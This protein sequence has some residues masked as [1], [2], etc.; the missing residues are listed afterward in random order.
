MKVKTIRLYK[1]NEE[2]IVEEKCIREFSEL[3]YQPEPLGERGESSDVG[4]SGKGDG[5]KAKGRK[6]KDAPLPQ[7]AD[8]AG[9]A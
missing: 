4:E 1:D 2:V 7:D 6:A 5:A 8:E 9:G 3:G